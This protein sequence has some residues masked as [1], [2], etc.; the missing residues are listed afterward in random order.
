MSNI[1]KVVCPKCGRMLNS[2]SQAYLEKHIA[3][4]THDLGPIF[5]K[6]SVGRP[7]KEDKDRIK[8]KKRKLIE[9]LE[10]LEKEGRRERTGRLLPP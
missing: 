5:L 8:K 1:P 4:C 3:K 7:C 6:G 9:L 2:Y 10:E